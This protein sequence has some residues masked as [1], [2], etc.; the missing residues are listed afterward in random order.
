MFL[1]GRL[2]PDALSIGAAAADIAFTEVAV[3]CAATGTDTPDPTNTA[4]KRHF[5]AFRTGMTFLHVN[6]LAGNERQNDTSWTW[7]AGQS[8]GVRASA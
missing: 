2:Y 8:M 6:S 3:D 5:N 7:A 1:G 4:T